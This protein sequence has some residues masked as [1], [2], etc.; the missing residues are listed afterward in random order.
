M[1]SSRPR[2]AI[3]QPY[4][5]PYIG[6][7]QLMNTVDIFVIYDNI[8]YTKKGWINRNRFLLHGRDEM[9]TIPLKKESDHLH[10]NQR[11][12]SDSFSSDRVKLKRRFHSAYS[13]APFY[14][15]SLQILNCCLESG[16][17][18]LF[19]FILHSVDVIRAHLGITSQLVCSSSIP[20]DH[21]LKAQDKVIAICKQLD[22]LEYINPIGGVELYEREVFLDKGIELLFHKARSIKYQQFDSNFLP[23]LSI[24]DM[25]MFCGTQRTKTYLSEMELC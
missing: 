25:L 12:I 19:D 21:E 15:E 3:M 14:E 6:Y 23:S 8:E 22:A 20:I 7:W 17:K 1:N 13:K 11:T 16:E 5:L 9:F 2:V 10:V 4:F 24:I 18:N